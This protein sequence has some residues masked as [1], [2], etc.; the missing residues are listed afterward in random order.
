MEEGH[1]FLADVKLD[2]CGCQFGY[3]LTLPSWVAKGVIDPLSQGNA[4]YHN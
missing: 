3:H 2:D 4:K 1:G